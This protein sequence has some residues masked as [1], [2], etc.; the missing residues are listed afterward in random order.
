MRISKSF[1]LAGLLLLAGSDAALA[2]RRPMVIQEGAVETTA[3][4]L[5]LPGNEQ[6]I[7]T[8]RGC[9]T[10]STQTF[11]LDK[12]VQFLLGGRHVSLT[13]MS[14][15]LRSASGAQVTLHYRRT[16]SLVTRVVLA[17]LPGTAK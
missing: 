17:M 12:Q 1:V 11:Y 16:D 4:E 7:V 13:E 10:C 5:S 8:V 15:A 3:N 14:V 2:G 6:G 9:A